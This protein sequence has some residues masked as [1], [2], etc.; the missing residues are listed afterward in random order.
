MKQRLWIVTAVVLSTAPVWAQPNNVGAMAPSDEIAVAELEKV[1]G[2]RTTLELKLHDLTTEQ[3]AE[4][5]SESSGLKVL[6]PLASP[7]SFADRQAPDAS[8]AAK[9]D[10]DVGKTDFW[11]ALRH[12]ICHFRHDKTYKTRCKYLQRVLR[13]NFERKDTLIFLFIYNKGAAKKLCLLRRV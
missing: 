8:Q 1:S 5:I 7:S 4:K 3:V 2:G 11:L 12:T 10:G 13:L 9:W 6:P